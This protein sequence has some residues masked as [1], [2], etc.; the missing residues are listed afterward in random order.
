M[1]TRKRKSSKAT[2]V[3]DAR[4]YDYEMVL[5]ISPEVVDEK[6]DA[7]IE[8]V[9]RFITDNGGSVSEVEKWGKKKLA[10]PI[11]QHVEGSY[12]LM[13]IKMKPT[14]GKEL[15]AK[16]RISEDI[17]RHLLIRPDS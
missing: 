14:L 13:K 12:L 8:N 2:Q 4:L 7:A 9:S 10:Y 3:I 16:L 6:F 15:E 1:V 11:K 17:L 5:I